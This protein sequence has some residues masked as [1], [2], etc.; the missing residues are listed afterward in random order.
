MARGAP[1]PK[2]GHDKR[3]CVCGCGRELK[4]KDGE[5]DFTRIFFD[6]DCR[7][8]DKAARID[9]QRRRKQKKIERRKTCPTCK[10]SKLRFWIKVKG[11]RVGLLNRD[12]AD[13]IL[14]AI[15]VSGVGTVHIPAEIVGSTAKH[16]RAK[17]VAAK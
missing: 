14:A 1:R 12:T 7:G 13:K 4:D 3:F 2:D 6:S 9:Q 8:R 10:R 5:T 16:A 11:V 17:K 15:P